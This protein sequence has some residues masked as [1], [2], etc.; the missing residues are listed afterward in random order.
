M[1]RSYSEETGE[2]HCAYDDGDEAY[3]QIADKTFEILAH[4]PVEVPVAVAA[5]ALEPQYTAVKAEMS[6]VGGGTG[7][8]GTPLLVGLARPLSNRECY[9][10]VWR[11]VRDTRTSL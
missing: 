8:L 9:A 11:Q 2:H 10:R 5:Q 4:A 7:F 1:V 6:R 3:Y